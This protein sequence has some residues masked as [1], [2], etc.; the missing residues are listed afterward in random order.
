M[1]WLFGLPIALNWHFQSLKVA[2][3]LISVHVKQ[4]KELEILGGVRSAT[5]PFVW[6]LWRL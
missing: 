6:S 3:R 5:R 1:L 2:T 4:L